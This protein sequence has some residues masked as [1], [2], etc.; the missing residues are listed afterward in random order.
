MSAIQTGLFLTHPSQIAVSM[1]ENGDRV[2]AAV[3]LGEIFHGEKALGTVEHFCE[4][5]LTSV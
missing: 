2:N 3:S 5:F 4:L 1:S